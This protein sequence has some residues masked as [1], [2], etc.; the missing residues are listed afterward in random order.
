MSKGELKS[1]FHIMSRRLTLMCTGPIPKSKREMREH[2]RQS[3][4][5]MSAAAGLFDAAGTTFPDAPLLEVNHAGN[6]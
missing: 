3:Q 5:A 6:R 2:I 4:I 1:L